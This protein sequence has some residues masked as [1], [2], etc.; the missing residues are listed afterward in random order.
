MLTIKKHIVIPVFVP[1]KGCPYDC[2]F[3]NQKTISGQATEA[4][5]SDI[6][7]TIEEH[8]KTAGSAF[9]EIGFYGGS[10]TGISKDEQEWYLKIGYSYIKSGRVNQ[11]RLSTRPDY[12]SGDILEHLARYGV[13]II[14]LGA[15]SLDDRVLGCSNRGHTLE[16]VVQA[17]EMIKKKGFSLGIQ[18]MIGLPEDT[19]EKALLT[20][21]KV[22]QIDPDFVRIYPTLVIRNTYLQKMY[23]QGRYTPLTLEEA[24]DISA[25]LLE[26]YEENNINVIR[27]GLQPTE[28]ISENGEVI[29]GPFHP[30]LRQ[31]VQSRLLR[32][33]LEKYFLNNKVK[34]RQEVVIECKPGEVSNIVGQK[35]QNIDKLRADFNI[36]SIKVIEREGIDLFR[37]I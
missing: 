30:A 36:G 13:K 25:K 14:E 3:C 9:V 5:E 4:S 1:H 11:L 33:K 29:A 27:I 12:I 16:T 15:Q 7:N 31:L 20:A 19:A 28:S 2:I 26:L 18:T 34:D 21:K 8:L 32:N 22:I 10:F 6:R 17:S 23:E 35:R 37:I 24:V